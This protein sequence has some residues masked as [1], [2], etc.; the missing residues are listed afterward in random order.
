MQDIDSN[1]SKPVTPEEYETSKDDKNEK[2]GDEKECFKKTSD[3][4]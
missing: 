3:E 4:K 2:S 1:Q